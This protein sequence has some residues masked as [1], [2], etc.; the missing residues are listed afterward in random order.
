MIWWLFS[1]QRR[2]R[3]F[4]TSASIKCGFF[5]GVKRRRRQRGD[6]DL[7]KDVL[8]KVSSLYFLNKI[9]LVFL[10]WLTRDI[11]YPILPTKTDGLHPHVVLD[12]LIH[13]D[14]GWFLRIAGEGYS[15]E[16]APFFPLLPFFIRLFSSV[17][18]DFVVAGFLITNISL[19]VVCYLFYCMVREDY[20]EDLAWTA[21]LYLLFFPTAVF[22][23]TIYSESLLLVFIL[24]AFYFA[25]R[26]NWFWAGFFGACAAL[27]RNIGV[28]LFLVFLYM[29]L[30][31]N[32]FKVNLKQL[33]SILP[34]PAALLIFMFVLLAQTG[35][36]LAFVHSLNTEYWGYRHFSYPGAGQWLNLKL[37]F[38][39]NEFYSI[40]ESLAAI[41][42]LFV[43]VLSFNYLKDKTMLV[44]L[45]LGFL[46]PFSVVVDNL[47]LGM[48]R[49]VIVLFPAYI[50]LAAFL[51]K[52]G[53][54]HVYSVLSIIAFSV[55]S[56]M[57]TAGRWIS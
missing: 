53:L 3:L 10:I 7:D 19:F 17:T 25:R 11:L 18:G 48:P 45:V 44:F 49:Y 39:N 30:K 37:F 55:I 23:S 6:S 52:Y 5:A 54:T 47:P 20:D 26:K 36:P 24:S 1:W 35:D 13:W 41:L 34:I 56:V 43:V 42:F 50:T 38:Y 12:S 8:K 4:L 32:N 51:R 29:Q 57:F 16:S 28:V 27:T 22:F 21:V 9:Y 40:Y 33:L 15:F 31:N 46:I 14:A 2:H